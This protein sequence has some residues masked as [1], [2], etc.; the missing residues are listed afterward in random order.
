MWQ[1]PK[2]GSGQTVHQGGQG[3]PWDIVATDDTVYWV[4]M[5]NENLGGVYA[6][7]VEALSTRV[8]IAANQN[9]AYKVRVD[10]DAVY[11]IT[12]DGKTV[13][14]KPHAGGD[15]ITLATM[16]AFG[17]GFAM[18]ATHLYW[19][20]GGSEKSIKKIGKDGCG[21]EV[22]TMN[23][24]QYTMSMDVDDTHIYWTDSSNGQI[25]RAPK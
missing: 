6:S 17:Y 9:S 14:K 10:D 4:D 1:V 2:T 3:Y 18:D 8:T 22:I 11:W 15:S 23:M 20:E 12:Q 16:N 7:S 21:E 13:N 25:L 5:S 24:A 19:S